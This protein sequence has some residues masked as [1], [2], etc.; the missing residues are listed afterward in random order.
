[1][2]RDPEIAP[3][4]IF[5]DDATREFDRSRFEGRLEAPLPQSTFVSIAAVLS[6]LFLI[7]IVRSG[8]LEI[9]SGE[10]FAQVS[11]HNSLQTTTLFAPRGPITDIHGVVLAENVTNADDTISR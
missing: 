2:R 5:L 4:E 1:M 10:A 9:I 7:L 8:H 3:D 6:L 11:A